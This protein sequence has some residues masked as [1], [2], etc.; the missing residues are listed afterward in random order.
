MAN[1]MARGLSGMA[2]SV[3]KQC[4][5]HSVVSGPNNHIDWFDY[6][7]PPLLRII[8]FRLSD[9]QGEEKTLI[10]KMYIS[11]V[12]LLVVLAV[13]VFSTIVFSLIIS[14]NANLL[15]T[16]FNLFLLSSLGTLVFFWGYYGVAKRE[17]MYLFLYRVVG[18]GLALAYFLFSVLSLGAF[19]GWTKIASFKD[20]S[21][22]V[23]TFGVTMCVIESLLYTANCG[24][25]MW[26]LYLVHTESVSVM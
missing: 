23:V 24:L 4:D 11:W 6:N 5:F 8:H 26:C 25:Q 1:L 15:Y 13:N 22:G 16:F 18:L 20:S 19:N 9:F 3:S 7:F 14:F 12:L 17:T 10:K 2:S 21:E